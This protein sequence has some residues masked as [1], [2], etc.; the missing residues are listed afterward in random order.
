MFSQT[1]NTADTILAT[2][3]SARINERFQKFVY[4]AATVLAVIVGVTAY[5]LTALL[6]WWEDNREE[7]KAKGKKFLNTFAAFCLGL[8]ETGVELR[9][10]VSKFFNQIA[11]KVYFNYITE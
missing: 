2:I 9:P 11:D 1:L 10:V 5:L 3:E 7:V 6:V 8:Y 4:H